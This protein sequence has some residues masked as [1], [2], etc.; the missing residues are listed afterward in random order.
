MGV[1]D[2]PAFIDFILNKTDGKNEIGKI[3][4]FVGQSEGTT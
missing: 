2:I 1:Y 3:A 4:A